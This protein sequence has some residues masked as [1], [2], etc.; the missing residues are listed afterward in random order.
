MITKEQFLNGVEFTIDSIG[1][2]KFEPR[3]PIGKYKPV[4]AIERVYRHSKTGELLFKDYEC[5]V[6]KI[7]NK[8]ITYYK[9][10]MGKFIKNRIKFE[11]MEEYIAPEI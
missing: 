7:T 5:N 11:D 9:S 6:E 2:F 4:G 8:T 3:E 1:P 10:V